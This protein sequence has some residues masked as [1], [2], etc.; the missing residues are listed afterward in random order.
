LGIVSEPSTYR[1]FSLGDAPANTPSLSPHSLQINI[2]II[3]ACTPSLKAILGNLL[4]I[5]S[6][7]PEARSSGYATGMPGSHSNSRSHHS[8]NRQSHMQRSFKHRTGPPDM[9]RISDDEEDAFELREHVVVGKEDV[10]A[11]AGRASSSQGAPATRGSAGGSFTG[12]EDVI[13]G[14]GG[15]HVLPRINITAER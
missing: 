8:H 3:A 6:L 1:L 2:G 13:L 7:T 9:Q 15:K 10:E 11:A 5:H 4:Q 14:E 12:S